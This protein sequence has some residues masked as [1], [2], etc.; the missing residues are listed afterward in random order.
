M[1]FVKGTIVCLTLEVTLINYV[2]VKEKKK[3]LS[4]ITIVVLKLV[5]L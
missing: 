5:T 3:V 4:F 1:V 2:R